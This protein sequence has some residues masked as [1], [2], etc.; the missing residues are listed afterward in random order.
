MSVAAPPAAGA[1]PTD[2]LLM[3][4]YAAHAEPA[5]F[6][7]LFRRHASAL[8]GFFRNRLPAT[9]DPRDLVQQTFM[10][11]HRSRATYRVGAPVRPWL[12]TIAR[13]VHRK[14]LRRAMS[15]PESPLEVSRHG[16][17]VASP[18]QTSAVQRLVRRAVL[19]LPAGQ[20]EVI[21]RHWFAGRSFP[22]IARELGVSLSAVKVRAHRGYRKLRSILRPTPS[23]GSGKVA[24]C[25]S[26]SCSAA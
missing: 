3:S 16:E 14:H 4:R 7:V 13:N 10:L 20:R 18:S 19:E 23:P 2:E 9:D 8:Q 6:E 5:C 22:E 11:L 21:L 26:W 25:G 24:A 1:G 12:F 15:R 17:P